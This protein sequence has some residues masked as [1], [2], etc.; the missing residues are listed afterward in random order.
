MDKGRTDGGGSGGNSAA[1]AATAAAMVA[2]GL[3]P[4]MDPA[5]AA[6]YGELGSVWQLVFVCVWQVVYLW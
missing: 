2:A 5:T 4:G 3:P 1:A 6:L